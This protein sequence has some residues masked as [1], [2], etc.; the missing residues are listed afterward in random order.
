M[1]IIPIAHQDLMNSKIA[2]HIEK[3]KTG[4]ESSKK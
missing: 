3:L 2:I 1:R 4:T